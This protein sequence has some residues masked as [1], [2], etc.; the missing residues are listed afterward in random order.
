LFRLEEERR[1]AADKEKEALLKL[2]GAGEG[3][4]I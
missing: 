3:R 4:L 2:G 1:R